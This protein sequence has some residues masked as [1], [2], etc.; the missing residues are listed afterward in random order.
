M[1]P[2][3]PR[4][5]AAIACLCLLLAACGK[6]DAPTRTA[7]PTTPQE[8]WTQFQT[9]IGAKDYGRLYDLLSSRDHRAIAADLDKLKSLGQPQLDMAAGKL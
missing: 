7:G 8:C 9:A 1:T 6:K 3:G 5:V 2:P 4:A